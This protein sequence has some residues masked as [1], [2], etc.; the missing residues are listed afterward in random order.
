MWLQSFFQSNCDGN[1]EHDYDGCRIASDSAPGWLFTFDLR[2]TPYE[3]AKL[4]LLEDE[5]APISWLR[6]QIADGKFTANCSPKRLAECIDLLRD[7][8]EGRR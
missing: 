6:C 2:G 8:I 5:S 7:V 1:W 3:N 4:D